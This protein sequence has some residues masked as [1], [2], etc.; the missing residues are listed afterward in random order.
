MSA[1]RVRARDLVA[2]FVFV[3]VTGACATMPTANPA[4]PL[5]KDQVAEVGGAGSAVV[6]Y[7][8]DGRYVPLDRVGTLGTVFGRVSFLD[9]IDVMA[10]L[11]GGGA[12]GLGIDPKP[13]VAPTGLHYLYGG[14]LSLVFRT[15]V[16]QSLHVGGGFHL[17]YQDSTLGAKLDRRVG[18]LVSLPM[19]ERVFEDIFITIRPTAGLYVPLY[20]GAAT[21]FF[22][23]VECPIGFSWRISK[24]FTL[25]AEGGYHPPSRGIV[26]T[27][28]A[29]VSF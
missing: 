5:P 15:T 12:L 19:S 7:G 8:N 9:H 27:G 25:L 28:G 14:R 23:A 4:G 6:G 13:A 26:A 18:A 20:D 11:H 3:A 29:S 24:W 10:H 1:H 17:D 2:H 21:P 22:A 16:F